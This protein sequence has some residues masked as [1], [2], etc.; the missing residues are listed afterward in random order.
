[1]FTVAKGNHQPQSPALTD[2]PGMLLE[3]KTPLACNGKNLR[4]LNSS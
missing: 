1:M 2:S 3:P 4:Q